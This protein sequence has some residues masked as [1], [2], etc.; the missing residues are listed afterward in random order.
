MLQDSRYLDLANNPAQKDCL[1]GMKTALSGGVQLWNKD[2]SYWKCSP[3]LREEA[4]GW[5]SQMDVYTALP[6]KVEDAGRKGGVQKGCTLF[7][8]W[9]I[10]WKHSLC[11]CAD[12]SEHRDHPPPTGSSLLVL[13]A[14]FKGFSVYR[15]HMFSASIVLILV[16]ISQHWLHSTH[17]LLSLCL[18]QH[19]Q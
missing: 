13:S 17:M 16:S 11:P 14:A 2:T 9:L 1:M 18:A 3:P 7:L 8:C 4:T 15:D 10:L 12:F 19:T 5:L 6:L